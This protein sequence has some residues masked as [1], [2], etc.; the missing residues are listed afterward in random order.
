MIY[1]YLIV[2]KHF[3]TL[4]KQKWVLTNLG[5]SLSM[6]SFILKANNNH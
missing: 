2:L 4:I 6:T 5:L 1:Q 3:I